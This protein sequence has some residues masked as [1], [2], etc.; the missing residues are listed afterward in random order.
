MRQIPLLTL[1]LLTTTLSAIAQQRVSVDVKTVQ[2]AEGKRVTTE[3][4]IYLTSDGRMIAEQHRPVH[5]ISLANSIGEMRIYDPRKNEVAMVSDKELAS[6]KEIVA[7]FAWGTYNDMGLP[8]YGFRQSNVRYEDGLTIKTFTPKSHANISEVELVFQN[9]LPICMIY[10]DSKLQPV[11][12]VY[13]SNYKH[14]RIPMPMRITEIEYSSPRDSVVRLS[15]YSNLL[16][17]PRANSPMFD[18]QVPANAKRT[19]VDLNKLVQ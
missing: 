15:T 6:G 18:F 3:R 14:D 10:Y 11:R 13:F 8:A 1:L 16:V 4:S 7:M 19:N 9:L 5:L 12:K 17:G 2:V